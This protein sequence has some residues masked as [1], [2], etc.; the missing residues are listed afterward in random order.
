MSTRT[1]RR[2]RVTVAAAVAALACSA[3]VVSHRASDALAELRDRGRLLGTRHAATLAPRP[4]IWGDTAAGS[5]FEHYERAAKLAEPFDDRDDVRPLLELDDPAIACERSR[6]AWLPIVDALRAG[7]RCADHRFPRADRRFGC[8]NLLTYRRAA[9]LTLL[10]ARARRAEGRNVDAAHLT[11]DVMAMGA[12]CVQ[13]GVLINQMVGAALVSIAV[14]AWPDDALRAAGVE[15]LQALRDG[16]ARVDARLP[17]TL[18]LDAELREMADALLAVPDQEDWCGVG[19]WRYGFST[20]WMVADAF[21]A[22]ADGAERM[23]SCRGAPWPTRQ[24]AFAA[25]IDRLRAMDNSAAL[26]IAPNLESCELQLRWNLAN[27]RLLRLAVQLHLR[28]P[29]TLPDPLGEGSLAV[30][31]RDDDFELSS[32]GNDARDRLRRLARP[33]PQSTGARTS[34]TKR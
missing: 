19:S 25:E 3:A 21:L 34:F 11:L 9:N 14:D 7:A 20:R 2:V 16:L 28:E 5:A 24:A 13:D 18:D 12:A 29:F 1:H 6:D 32:A 26:V 27:L 30:T 4:A 23:R 10:E 17:A 31:P 15:A 22:M 8:A 33:E